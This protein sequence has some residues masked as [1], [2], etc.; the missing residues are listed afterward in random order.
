MMALRSAIPA[1]IGASIAILVF[2]AAMAESPAPWRLHGTL[3]GDARPL[4]CKDPDSV[5][6]IVDVLGRAIQSRAE[7]DADKA[8]QLFEIAA[9][10][11]GEICLRPASDDIVI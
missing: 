3:E 4:L 2:S 6:L 10:L 7:G 11:E 9:K 5:N 8:K 1:V